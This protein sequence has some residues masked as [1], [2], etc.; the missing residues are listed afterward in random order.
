MTDLRD[1][2]ITERG[3]AA[4]T[5][6]TPSALRA[7]RIRELWPWPITVGQLERV[8]GTIFPDEAILRVLDR[9]GGPPRQQPICGRKPHPSAAEIAAA[10]ERARAEGVEAAMRLAHAE[11]EEDMARGVFSRADVEQALRLALHKH[12]D[13]WHAWRSSAL[14]QSLRPNGPPLPWFDDGDGVHELLEEILDVL[15]PTPE[16]K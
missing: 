11:R 7:R 2:P 5:D 3:A 4:L 1:R 13:R 8:A 12:H 16:E 15:T 9:K 10:I 6:M 14:E